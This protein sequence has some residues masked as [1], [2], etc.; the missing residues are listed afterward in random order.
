MVEFA[1]ERMVLLMQA[2]NAAGLSEFSAFSIMMTSPAAPCAPC[3]PVVIEETSS[4]LT[5]RWE[6]SHLAAWLL[7]A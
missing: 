4:S 3:P 5:I 2:R 7:L 1:I 6:V